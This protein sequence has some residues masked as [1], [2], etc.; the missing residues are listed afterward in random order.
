LLCAGTISFS[1]KYS[2]LILNF[3]KIIVTILKRRSQSA[4]NFIFL[5]TNITKNENTSETLC[6]NSV[7]KKISVHVPTH[8]KPINEN[9]FG[10]YL[11]GLI[12][13]VGH[14]SNQKQLLIVFNEQDASLA[15]FIKNQIGYG[16]IYKVKNKKAII[17]VISK[18]LGIINV[19][20]LI[21]GKIISE[22]KLNQINKNILSNPNFNLL[23]HFN[24]NT[25]N[26]FNNHWLAGFSDADASFQIKL[27]TRNNKTE[28]RLNFQIDQKQNE[29]LILIKNFLGGNIGYRKTQDF[30]NYCSDS[31][32]SARK[33]IN[34]FDCFHLLSSKYLDY[35][36]WRKTYIYV[37]ISSATSENN[38][39]KIKKWSKLLT[40]K[41]S[42]RLSLDK[43]N[44]FK[45][46]NRKYST[47]SIIK[48]LPLLKPSWVTG[49]ADAEGSFILSITKNS[50]YNT[51]WSVSPCFRIGLHSKDLTLLIKIQS[52]FGVGNIVKDNKNNLFFY[53]VYSITD[54]SNIIIPHFFKY[55]LLTQKQVDFLLF[56]LAIEII[57]RKEHLT[58]EGLIKIL[59]I[60]ASLN[61]ALT[62][63]LIKYFPNII[64][65][66][67]PKV[68]YP[69]IIDPNWLVGF[70]DGEGCFFVNIK[71]SKTHKTG[72]Q[73]QVRFIL[74]QHQ[75]DLELME[76]IVQIL[77]CGILS[78]E[79]RNPSIYLTVTK[80]S[81]NIRVVSFFNNYS[82]QS[83][84]KLDFTDFCKV[85]ELL[86]NKSHF[87]L[88]G[89]NKIKEIKAGMNTGRVIKD[90]LTV[91]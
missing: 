16:N 37:K 80:L 19:L 35:L 25:N 47:N 85:V 49:F 61:K 84:K 7:I 76:K 5:Q 12:D 2:N 86:K 72:S 88:E 59:E 3:K 4:G 45:F 34:Y 70:I 90:D 32:G 40:E 20:N 53:N 50:R 51:G 73:V 60:K 48:S 42:I 11:A 77:G 8:L 28:V 31:Y 78:K 82:L 91:N 18:K 68:Q 24:K 9:E 67:R 38:L 69:L 1:F 57:K 33:I 89:L 62:D 41:D 58:T 27:I 44:T 21:N 83:S 71:F 81:D 22:N 66:H 56:N 79:K 26:D 36:R 6:N 46:N 15:Y 43:L 63:E 52:F 74:T 54:L 23:T 75:R 17:L 55:P 39:T 64:S 87:T 65:I 10:H 14:F 30:Y 13:G 29:L